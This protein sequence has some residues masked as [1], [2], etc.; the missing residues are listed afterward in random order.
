M[1]SSLQV[2]RIPGPNSVSAPLIQ[3]ST[4]ANRNATIDVGA[5]PRLLLFH[6][7]N[8]RITEFDLPARIPVT[9][10]QGITVL[11]FTANGF[12][13]DEHGVNGLEIRVYV[14]ESDP[15]NSGPIGG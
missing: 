10:D 5:K 9:E 7:Q 14:L 3:W 15:Q 1:R 12:E 8:L 13:V 2:K 11:R 6:S 4:S